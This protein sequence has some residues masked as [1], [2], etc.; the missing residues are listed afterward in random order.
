ML[1]ISTFISSRGHIRWRIRGRWKNEAELFP[2]QLNF[3]RH[4]ISETIVC[5]YRVE[6]PATSAAF[7]SLHRFNVSIV[8]EFRGGQNG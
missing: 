4:V 5:G 2:L 1:Y 3:A 6:S 7:G 8:I